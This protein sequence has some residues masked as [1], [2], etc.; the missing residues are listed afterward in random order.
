MHVLVRAR[1]K[2]CR[3][4]EV[5]RPKVSWEKNDAAD[6]SERTVTCPK[7]PRGSWSLNADVRSLH[8]RQ[9]R[10]A[11][12]K[13]SGKISPIADDR[14]SKGSFVTFAILFNPRLKTHDGAI[15]TKGVRFA[16]E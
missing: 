9:I 1:E 13:I 6:S 3:A 11:S 2:R 15:R 5:E 14:T 7:R 12:G 4:D 8:L 10:R 16:D